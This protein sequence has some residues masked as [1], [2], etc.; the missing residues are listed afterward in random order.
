MGKIY[1]YA[2]VSAEDQEL[3]SRSV[4]CAMLACL[5]PTSCKRRRQIGRCMMPCCAG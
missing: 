2:R 1:G 4:R 5:R 3:G